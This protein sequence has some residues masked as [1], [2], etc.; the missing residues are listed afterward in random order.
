[1]Y[2]DDV[3]LSL[4]A[5]KADLNLYFAPKSIVY[6]HD[7]GTSREN[8][9]LKM[10]LCEVNRLRV[11]KKHFPKEYDKKVFELVHG[12]VTEKLLNS[13][14]E[15]LKSAGES[16][17]EHQERLSRLAKGILERLAKLLKH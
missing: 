10:A 2:C 7:S 4:R 9:P 8:L 12:L 14:Q 6:H 1:M 11:L 5:K 3:D 15:V 16:H 13:S 17:N